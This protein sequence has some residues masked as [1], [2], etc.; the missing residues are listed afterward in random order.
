MTPRRTHPP[1]PALE[2]EL[3]EIRDRIDDL[4]RRLVV[5]L[6]ERAELGRAAGRAKVALGRRAVRDTEREREVLIRV[7]M[8]NAGPI[9]SADLLSIFRRVVAV[10][11][12]LETRDRAHDRDA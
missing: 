6:N 7:A 11:R 3:A 10:T 9:G 8:A 1:D 4:D 5:M 2:S 12:G